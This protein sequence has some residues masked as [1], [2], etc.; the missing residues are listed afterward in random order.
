MRYR[1]RI[2]NCRLKCWSEILVACDT[3]E[4]IF[5]FINSALATGGFVQTIAA[6]AVIGFQSLEVAG[7]VWCW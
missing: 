7:T 1:V 6:M 3:S 4:E 5:N 2:E